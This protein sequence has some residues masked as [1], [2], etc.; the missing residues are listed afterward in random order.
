MLFLV[1]KTVLPFLVNR[2][3]QTSSGQWAKEKEPQK[4]TQII[5]SKTNYQNK[6]IM[7]NWPLAECNEWRLSTLQPLYTTGSFKEI[8]D[9]KNTRRKKTPTIHRNKPVSKSMITYFI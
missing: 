2:L 5:D 3:H 9:F 1:A 8:L 4:K 7:L 6:Y